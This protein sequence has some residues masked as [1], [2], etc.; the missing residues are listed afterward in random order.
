VPPVKGQV[1]FGFLVFLAYTLAQSM[2]QSLKKDHSTLL[3]WYLENHRPLPWRQD[4]D[5]YKIWISEIMLQQTTVTAVVP[6]FER[7]MKLFPNVEALASA[8]LELVLEAWSGLGYYTR[9]RNLHKA[10]MILAAQ[11]FAKSHSQLIELPG[12]GPYTSRAISSIAFD[13]KVGVLDGNVIRI[14]SRRYGWKLEWWKTKERETLQKRSDELAAF[15]HSSSFNQAMMELGATVCTPQSP[16]CLLCP[17]QTSCVARLTHQV[18]QIP[19]SKP[20]RENEFWAYKPVWSF[21]QG[22][23]LL[24]SEHEAPFLKN[25]L[26]F[27]GSFSRLLKKPTHFDL[28][29]SITHH[30]IYIQIDY[31]KKTSIAKSKSLKSSTKTRTKKVSIKNTDSLKW[32]PLTDLKR[33]NP[34]SLLQKICAQALKKQ[35]EKE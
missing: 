22:R 28:R 13:E 24:T 14:L 10:A 8:P 25:Q 3:N 16:R 27:P 5:P 7:F 20:K 18:K 30:D 26:L 12:L 19:L 9:A 35:S 21:D 2:E 32:V 15:G 17:W 6:F 4:R 33:W 11:G 1:Y 31:K 29:H 34:S 23:V